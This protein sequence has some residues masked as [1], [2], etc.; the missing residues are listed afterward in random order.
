MF[1]YYF[2]LDVIRDAQIEAQVNT[3]SSLANPTPTH[4]ISTRT[5]GSETGTR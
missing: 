2:N 3:G 1:G 4:K 5:Q